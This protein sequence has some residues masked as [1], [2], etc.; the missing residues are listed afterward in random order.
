MSREPLWRRY[1]RF[2][3]RNVDAD[4]EDE[5]RF[6]L[7]MRERHYEALGLSP[8]QARDAAQERFGDCRAVQWLLRLLANRTAFSRV[9]ASPNRRPANLGEA[10]ESLELVHLREEPVGHP[11]AQSAL[12]HRNHHVAAFEPMG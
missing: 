9:S 11:L 3:G 1:L 6:H 2:F 8:S 5:L 7:E 4:I 12:E 10:L